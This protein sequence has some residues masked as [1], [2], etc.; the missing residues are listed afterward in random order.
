[1]PRETQQTVKLG[2][3]TIPKGTQLYS[4]IYQVHHD[5][6]YWKDP[7][8]F[9]PERF[10]DVEGEFV[11]DERCIPFGLGKRNCMGQALAMNELYLFIGNL[12]QQLEF[13]FERGRPEPELEPI[14][15]FVLGCPHY[16]LCVAER[17]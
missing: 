4:F 16:K 17:T 2:G 15:G 3:Y 12:V 9:R 11:K 8:K 1:M 10:L 14:A 13:S 5:K 6:A 7:E